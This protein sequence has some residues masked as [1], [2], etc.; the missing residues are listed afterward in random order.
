MLKFIGIRV[1][2]GIVTM[3]LVTLVIFVLTHMIGSPVLQLL[4]P[5]YTQADFDTLNTALGYDRPLYEQFA[6]FIGRLL[7]GDLGNSTS[8]SQPVAAVIGSRLPITLTLAGL[9][10]AFGGILALL[11]G[12]IAGFTG[13]RAGEAI[14]TFIAT[15][16]LAVPPFAVGIIL[17]VIFAVNLRILPSGGWGQANQMILPALTLSLAVYAGVARVARS[18]MRERAGMEF[19]VLARTKGLTPSQ[20]FFNHTVRPSLPPVISYFAVLAGSLF[21]G[22]VVTEAVFGIPG[23]GTLAVQSVETRDQNLVI[24]IVLFSAFLF[25]FLN[26]VADLVAA[27]LDPRIKLSGGAES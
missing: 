7:R 14:V 19:V 24:G 23:L 12:F 9:A 21:S 8:F 4:P 6:S 11:S 10:L 22:A 13:S 18:S 16:G 27:A 2:R 17:I 15:L 20:I 26:V 5:N 1:L 3:A 25:V